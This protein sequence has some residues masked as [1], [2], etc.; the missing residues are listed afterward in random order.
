MSDSGIVGPYA[1]S[2]PGAYRNNGPYPVVLLPAVEAID[3]VDREQDPAPV[4][5]DERARF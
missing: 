5:E 3:S 2:V 4:E 1:Y